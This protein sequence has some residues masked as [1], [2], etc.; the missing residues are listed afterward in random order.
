MDS[1]VL[2]Y[3]EKDKSSAATF[4]VYKLCVQVA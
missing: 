3:P 2:D 1:F 4:Y